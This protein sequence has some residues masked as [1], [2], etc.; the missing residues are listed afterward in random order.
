[1]L[2]KHEAITFYGEVIC[3]FSSYYKYRFHFTGA[4]SDGATVELSQGGNADDIYR[5]EV[6]PDSKLVM[7]SADRVEI[8]KD[9]ELIYEENDWT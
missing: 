5:Y 2:T 8:T 1:M 6:Y 9:N 7:A 3:T 4:A